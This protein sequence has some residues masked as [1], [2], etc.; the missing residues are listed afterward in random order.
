M[1]ENNK[2]NN[3]II[4]IVAV[5]AIVIILIVALSLLSNNSSQPKGNNKNLPL[6]GYYRDTA[7]NPAGTYFVR[8]IEIKNDKTVNYVIG[9]ATNPEY[10]DIKIVANYTGTYTKDKY[11]DSVLLTVPIKSIDKNCVDSENYKC[12]QTI[13]L[14]KY[15]EKDYI[16]LIEESTSPTYDR[17][18]DP[19]LI[20]W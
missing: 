8:E 20:K 13:L 17:I 19:I 9:E 3:N 4:K 16:N 11:N 15:K 10:T 14:R 7:S 5:V 12:E 18:D 6:E 2:K 1:K